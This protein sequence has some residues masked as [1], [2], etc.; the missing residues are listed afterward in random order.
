[1]AETLG[2]LVD[3]L[4]IKE[5]RAYHIQEMIDQGNNKFSVEELN[6]RLTLLSKQKD[7]LIHEI[8]EYVYRA[9]AEDGMVLRDEKIKLYNARN[10]M[11]SIGSVSGIGQAIGGL[12][13]KNLELWHLE[14]EARRQDVPLDYIGDIKRKIDPVNQQRNDFIDKIDELF[15]QAVSSGKTHG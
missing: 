4:T 1:M 14:D 10:V 3:K 11:D 9:F 15:A 5:I 8:D 6:S 13:Q 12:A 7:D 2:S